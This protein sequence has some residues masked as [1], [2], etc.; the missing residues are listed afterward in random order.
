M[1]G[2]L[3]INRSGHL[4]HFT[5]LINW[6]ISYP[7]TISF[8][9][10]G[11]ISGISF[12]T[13]GTL[14]S[15]SGSFSSFSFDATNYINLYK[16]DNPLEKRLDLLDI[17]IGGE[18]YYES[19]MDLIWLISSQPPKRIDNKIYVAN[20]DFSARAK[21]KIEVFKNEETSARSILIF[22]YKK[23]SFYFE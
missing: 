20:I 14:L 19:V 23:G 3:I 18:Y 5:G 21:V 22:D 12:L 4:P 13:G 11:L 9:N 16:T 1:T 7:T 2:K 8:C 17:N 10:S 6:P 15:T